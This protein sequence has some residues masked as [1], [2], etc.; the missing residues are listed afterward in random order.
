MTGSEALSRQSL[1]IVVVNYGS[2]PLV[3]SNLLKT[4][5][6]RFDGQ[7]I[8]VDNFTS[9]AER[10]AV[11]GLGARYGW[12]VLALD[13]NEGFGG[14]CNRGAALAIESGAAE[15]LFLNP[16]AW[17]GLEAVD[18]LRA[19]VQADPRLQISPEVLRPNGTVYSAEMDLHL[20]IGEMR[21]TRRRPADADP[22]RIHTW[23][24]GAC[25][26][27]SAEFWTELGGF[28]ED[29]FLY[30]EDADL[31]RRVVMAGGKVRADHS[32]N[33]FHD[34]GGTHR[35]TASTRV[36][37]PI[38][39]YYNARNR[40]LYA[41]KHLTP[42]DARRWIRVTPRASYRILL[43]GGRRQF[44][45]PARSL[46]PALKGSLAGVRAFRAKRRMEGRHG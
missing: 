26:A 17:L 1:A 9:P 4:V 10:V 13:T 45:R 8:I 29:F 16:D 20:D 3:E 14:G 18:V 34:E 30:W 23:V 41:A 11:Q 46:W 19:H 27:I 28:D 15:L 22:Q 31:S 6:E 42:E 38:Y 25:F 21:A 37:S 39:Y 33:A 32:V 36:K 35:D 24:S 44:V 40:L 5:G 7:V 12:R 43:Q 2:H